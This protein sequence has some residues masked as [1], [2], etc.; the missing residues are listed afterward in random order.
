MIVQ[1]ST[2]KTLSPRTELARQPVCGAGR[3]QRRAA[4]PRARQQ[5]QQR[6]LV[7]GIEDAAGSDEAEP[8]AADLLAEGEVALPLPLALELVLAQAPLELEAL[9]R[10]ASQL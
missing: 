4:Q 5:R 6:S 7:R 3:A 8:V 2:P 1:T 10:P 9:A